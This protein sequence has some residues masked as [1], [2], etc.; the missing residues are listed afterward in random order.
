ME[1]LLLIRR[2]KRGWSTQFHSSLEVLLSDNCP[3]TSDELFVK[4][5][6]AI[7]NFHFK[8]N[9]QDKFRE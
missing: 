6:G 9:E 5:V 2:A 3:L 8:L 1:A 7:S 4:L